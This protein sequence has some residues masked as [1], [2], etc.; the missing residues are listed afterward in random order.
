MQTLGYALL[1]VVV[2]KVIFWIP[3]LGQMLKT[4][5]VATVY[6]AFLLMLFERK[7]KEV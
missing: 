7:K 5:A 4:I 1:T 6:G 2:I 3:L